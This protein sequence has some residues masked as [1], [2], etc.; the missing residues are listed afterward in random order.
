MDHKK[1][2]MNFTMAPSLSDIEILGESLLDI[3]PDDFDEDIEELTI[4]V[5]DLADDTIVNDLD[6][7]DPYELP[8]LYKNGSEISPG[9][10]KKTEK[11]ED[12]LVLYRKPILDMWVDSGE[13]LAAVVYRIM[14]EEIAR[15]YDY[16]DEDIDE[17]L[18]RHHQ[19]L[20]CA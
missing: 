16:D 14:I 11:H 9:V 12:V 17:L 6:L 19:A 1:L 3:I 13:N 7:D 4:S 20:L 15:Y 5:D 18:A 2:F 10:E 8:A